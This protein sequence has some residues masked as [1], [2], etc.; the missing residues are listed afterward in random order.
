MVQR[1]GTKD[2]LVLQ[3]HVFRRKIRSVEETPSVLRRKLRADPI[4]IR[5]AGV[6]SARIIL[7]YHAAPLEKRMKLRHLQ[8]F[9]RHRKVVDTNLAAVA[10]RRFKRHIGGTQFQV[11]FVVTVFERVAE[12]PDK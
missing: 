1:A 6:A 8:P 11:P 12:N 5:N 7:E 2:R 9:D 10:A 4:S 3:W